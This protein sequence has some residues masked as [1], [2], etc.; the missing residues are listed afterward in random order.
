MRKN[1]LTRA[2]RRT[3]TWLF[4]VGATL[5]NL[6]LMVLFVG[7]FFLF[8]QAFLPL[9]N[10]MGQWTTRLLW[11]GLFLM[12]LALAFLVY[13]MLFLLLKKRVNLDQW[14][15]TELFRGFWLF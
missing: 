4:L 12:A 9:R 13:R 8:G 14:V 1:R 5:S 10:E 7:L 2:Q 6:V 3:N 11:T 15:D